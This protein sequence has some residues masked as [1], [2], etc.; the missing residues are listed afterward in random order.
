M[1]W[2][3]PDMLLNSSSDEQIPPDDKDYSNNKDYVII[4][5][6]TIWDRDNAN[7]TYDKD[8]RFL[9]ESVSGTCFIHAVSP[10]RWNASV[11]LIEAEILSVP[12]QLA[13][14]FSRFSFCWNFYF[15]SGIDYP[16]MPSLESH[17]KWFQARLT[18]H[19]LNATY[20]FVSSI[21]ITNM[22][23]IISCLFA[24]ARQ[25]YV[26]ISLGFI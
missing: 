1:L 4:L 18:G 22:A 5:G 13:I 21:T 26:V 24:F 19:A 12:G 8:E 16:S 9:L 23:K 17:L 2:P 10:L 20:S 11:S 25:I 3:V 6:N 14:P 7:S 15:S